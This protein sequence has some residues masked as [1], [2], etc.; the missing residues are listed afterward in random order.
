MMSSEIKWV[1]DVMSDN[2]RIMIIFPNKV[3]LM[4]II[5]LKYNNE[6]GD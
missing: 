2:K 4:Y 1:N 3:L 6:F 5:G